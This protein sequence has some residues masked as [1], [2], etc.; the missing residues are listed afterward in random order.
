MKGAA[1]RERDVDYTP[2][3]NGKVDINNMDT[4]ITIL[5]LNEFKM[6]CE[7]QSFETFY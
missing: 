3:N 1:K 7:F 4:V 2:A 5:I 6:Q